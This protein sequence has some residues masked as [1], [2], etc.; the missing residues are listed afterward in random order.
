MNGMIIVGIFAV[1]V[2]GY[3]AMMR[4]APPGGGNGASSDPET[5]DRAEKAPPPPLPRSIAYSYE[6]RPLHI[7]R[8]IF[9]IVIGLFL[10]AI[11]F[12]LVTCQKRRELQSAIENARRAGNYLEQPAVPGGGKK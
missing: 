3:W 10:M 1:L 12:D 11:L 7:G 6:P 2:A 5:A 9:G 4:P 8:W